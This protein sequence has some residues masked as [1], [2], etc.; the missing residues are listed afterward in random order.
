MRITG[1]GLAAICCWQ[2]SGRQARW[3]RS[4]ARGSGRVVMLS[5]ATREL[6][7]EVFPGVDLE[8][9]LH[10]VKRRI[11]RWGGE[12][13]EFPHDGVVVTENLLMER[14]E[15][16]RALECGLVDRPGW[17]LNTIPDPARLQHFGDR[18]ASAEETELAADADPHACVM[19]A[20]RDGWS[21]L[22]P[23]GG[24]SAWLL[25]AGETGAAV[26][27]RLMMEGL[28]E[29]LADPLVDGGTLACGAAAAAFDPICGD[30]V[31][32]AARMAIL[33]CAVLGAPGA[34]PPVDEYAYRI[35]LGMNRHLELCRQFYAMGGDS[36]W[37]R[38]QV[39]MARPV[40]LG[41]AAA[42]WTLEGFKLRQ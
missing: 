19:A 26:H 37:W 5:P 12:T 3:D 9:G 16:A 28:T 33:A 41:G 2:L 6:L 39:E 23:T 30:G 1:G 21:F 42:R 17:T 27:P 24:R 14:L 34:D 11:V 18:L 40:E 7:G 10:P 31:G 4:E 35:R 25:K 32:H 15:A 36:P 22:L 29:R 38:K 13:R 8:T 20:E